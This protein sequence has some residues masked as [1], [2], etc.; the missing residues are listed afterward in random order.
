MAMASNTGRG[1]RIDQIRRPMLVGIDITAW[2][3][4]SGNRY[5]VTSLADTL[6]VGPLE[7][8]CCRIGIL[9]KGLLRVGQLSVI[10]PSG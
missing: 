2:G 7:E 8:L 3:S 4:Q 1:W 5:I 9:I 10:L 6:A